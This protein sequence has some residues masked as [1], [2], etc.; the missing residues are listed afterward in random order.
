[1][2]STRKNEIETQHELLTPPW[3]LNSSE[4][5][6]DVPLENTVSELKRPGKDVN[7]NRVPGGSSQS[8]CSGGCGLLHL[9]PL[10][11]LGQLFFSLDSSFLLRLQPLLQLGDGLLVLLLGLDGAVEPSGSRGKRR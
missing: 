3:M 9:L 1:M 8:H 7:I 11:L 4:S 6:E 2:N 5:L 10:S